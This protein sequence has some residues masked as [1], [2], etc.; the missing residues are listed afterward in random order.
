MNYGQLIYGIFFRL[1]VGGGGGGG[2]KEKALTGH[3]Q[4]L[5]KLVRVNQQSVL[6][7]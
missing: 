5:V 2:E 4:S 6:N 7:L 3:F 1:R